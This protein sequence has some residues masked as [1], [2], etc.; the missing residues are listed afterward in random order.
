MTVL[1]MGGT[2]RNYGQAPDPAGRLIGIAFVLLL[3]LALVYAL[4]TGLGR[5]LV[6][7][8]QAPLMAKLIDEPKPPLENLPPPPPV[9]AAPPPPY[10]P[11]PEIT[12]RTPPSP[13][14]ITAVAHEKPPALVAPAPPAPPR[15]VVRTQPVADAARCRKPA[16]PLKSRRFGDEGTTVLEFLIGTSGKALQGRIAGSS[17]HPE[18]DEAALAALGQCDFTPGTADGKPEQSWATIRYT[19]RLHS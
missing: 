17:G 8:V 13:A 10:I 2:R 1:D 18:L 9:L 11:P 12:I 15:E 4:V 3:H 5:Q 14:A 6:E 16:Y 7:L 19:W